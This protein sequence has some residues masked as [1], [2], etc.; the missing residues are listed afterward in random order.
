MYERILFVCTGNTCR[1]PMA[2][3]LMRAFAQKEQLDCE[4]RSAGV[5]AWDGHPISPHSA[6]ILR[7]KG[8]DER[9]T[10]SQLTG[11]TVEWAD[12]ILTM[13]S[14]HKETVIRRFPEAVDKVYTLKEF[15]ED[16]P[17]A[18]QTVDERQQI[19]SEL[20]IKRSLGQPI[21]DEEM[22]RAKQLEAQMPNFDI[23]DPFGGD[24]KRYEQA[25]QEIEAYVIKL[26]GK[27]KR[28]RD[29]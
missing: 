28:L 19:Q 1:S 13:T 8:I 25:A 16:D 18:A 24:R 20:M 21:S 26:I 5:L 10:S 2:E 29:G 4:V 6:D 12:L 7:E 9:M 15:A 23:T 17:K 3:G 11:E 14:S 27:L 22:E